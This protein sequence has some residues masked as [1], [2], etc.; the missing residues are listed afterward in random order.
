MPTFCSRK[1]E[2][3]LCFPAPTVWC[4]TPSRRNAQV[5]E[6][7]MLLP[8]S[9]KQRI[10]NATMSHPKM[11][12]IRYAHFHTNLGP[13]PNVLNISNCLKCFSQSLSATG[14]ENS[15]GV[16]QALKT[17]FRRV[18]TEFWTYQAFSNRFFFSN[19]FHHQ[20]A[21]ISPKQ[22]KNHF[23]CWFLKA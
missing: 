16:H 5:A 22:M 18:F 13:E 19:K 21:F 4:G 1:L 11:H 7:S 17:Q 23:L 9:G 8:A 6:N 12:L 2:R 3:S 20:D 10:W 14:F 15:P